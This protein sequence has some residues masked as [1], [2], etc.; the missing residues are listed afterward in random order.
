MAKRGLSNFRVAVGPGLRVC[1]AW[2]GDVL[3]LRLAGGNKSNQAADIA[4]SR[5]WKRLGLTI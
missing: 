3:I 4:K 2:R 5:L 1:V